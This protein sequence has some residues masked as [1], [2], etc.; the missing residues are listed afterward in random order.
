MGAP[1]SRE[2][3]KCDT[4]FL[5]LNQTRG[6]DT[7]L[8]EKSYLIARDQDTDDG[9]DVPDNEAL[10]RVNEELESMAASVEIRR[11]CP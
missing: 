9:V 7:R 2:I 8:T 1:K 5:G 10:S 11:G 6:T 4:P 3:R